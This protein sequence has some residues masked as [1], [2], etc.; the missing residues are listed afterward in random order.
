MQYAP[1]VLTYVDYHIT[2]SLE[3]EGTRA[4][5]DEYAVGGT[6]T[7]LFNGGD[8][9]VGSSPPPESRYRS[10]IE[11]LRPDSASIA[12]V[13]TAGPGENARR[14]RVRV[15]LSI[16]AGESISRPTDCDVRML[17]Y[18]NNVLSNG[19]IFHHVVRTVLP[20]TALEI[21]TAGESTVIESETAMLPEWKPGDLHAV[22]WVQNRLT[23]EVLN[24]ATAPVRGPVPVQATTWG[25]IKALN[26]GLSR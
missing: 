15:E 22:A 19:R 2:G 1:E 14:L 11:R 25:R 17:L 23:Q 3:G 12:V 20:E 6:P 5:G 16:P 4:R 26:A 18:E 24:A 9:T 13:V 21:G 8:R 7:V 10:V